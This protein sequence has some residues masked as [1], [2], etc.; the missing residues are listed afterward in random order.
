MTRATTNKMK[1][2]MMTMTIRAGIEPLQGVAEGYS[3]LEPESRS[4]QP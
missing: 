4:L 1:T 2:M 3:T